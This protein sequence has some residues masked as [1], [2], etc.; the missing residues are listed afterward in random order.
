MI[1][2]LPDQHNAQKIPDL[3]EYNVKKVSVKGIGVPNPQTDTFRN[4]HTEQLLRNLE[5][6]ESIVDE[7]QERFRFPIKGWNRNILTEIAWLHTDRR[8]GFIPA[9]IKLLEERLKNKEIRIKGE[10]I[11]YDNLRKRINWMYEKGIIIRLSEKVGHGYQYVLANMQDLY[12]EKDNK[13][14]SIIGNNTSL[15]T[16]SKYVSDAIIEDSLYQVT[17]GR[18]NKEND[19]RTPCDEEK[20][21]ES[22]FHHISLISYLNSPKED[23]EKLK[24]SKDWI[25]CSEK[26]RGLKYEGRISR[27]RTFTIMVYPVGTVEIMIGC[28]KDPF[29]WFPR[30]DW[31]ILY[32]I[33]NSI[34]NLLKENLELGFSSNP[35]VHSTYLDWLVAQLHLGYD[36]QGTDNKE[37][38]KGKKILDLTKFRIPVRIRNLDSI[39]C[40]VY[41]KRMPYKGVTI[42]LEEHINFS[43]NNFNL[44]QSNKFSTSLASP[45]L[46][47]LKN[48]IA[49]KSIEQILENIYSR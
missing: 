3:N 11:G 10:M 15:H 40:Q 27:H 44:H 48:T 19:N 45:T 39:S 5:K 4:P 29:R 43:A 1:A 6:V 35:L 25:I 31:I 23:Y 42:R 16:N 8:K 18:D 38:R 32:D 21:P 30:E 49:P 2:R 28:T 22:E 12:V 34:L 9:T 41:V 26:N 13:D 7:L 20:Y 47:S 36:I 33:C 37:K 17:V 46:R 14:S 24:S